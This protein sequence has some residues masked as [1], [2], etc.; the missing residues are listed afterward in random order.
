MPEF[1][2]GPTVVAGE[3]AEHGP[4][5]PQ[6]GVDMKSLDEK[7]RPGGISVPAGSPSLQAAFGAGGNRLDEKERPD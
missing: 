1:R 2:Q 4:S 6:A 7:E 5:P 3:S